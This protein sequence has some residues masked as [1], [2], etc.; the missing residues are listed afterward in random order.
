M[1]TRSTFGRA[2]MD[3][4]IQARKEAE[5]KHGKLRLGPERWSRLLVEEF[6]EALDELQLLTAIE[7]GAQHTDTQRI[8]II[9]RAICELAQLTQ[10]S[11]GCITLLQE[12]L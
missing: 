4:V 8:E 9:E 11:M 1:N 3:A 6:D 7:C 2:A 5:A 10:L 12:M